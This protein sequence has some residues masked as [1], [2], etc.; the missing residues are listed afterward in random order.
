MDDELHQFFAFMS[1]REWI[2]LGVVLLGSLALWLAELFFWSRWLWLWVLRRWYR[3]AGPKPR[4]A[5]RWWFVHLLAVF[6]L[7]AFCYARFIEPNALVS[8]RLV[9]ETD[10]IPAG[11][12][13]RLVQV[14][15]LHSQ[16]SSAMRLV[17][18]A[19]E[20]AALRPDLVLLTG[21]YLCDYHIPSIEA[22]LG[23]AFR[24]P[25]VPAI[26]VPG[27]YGGFYPADPFLDQLGIE[28]LHTEWR[29]V[30]IRGVTFEILGLS[31]IRRLPVVPPPRHPERF[32]IVLEH[33]PA[34]LEPTAR[35]GWDLFLAGHTHAGQVRL[36]F[37]GAVV[38]LDPSGKEYEYGAYRL[39]RTIGYVN[40]GLGMECR[41][42][43]QVRFLAPPEVLLIELR[44][45]RK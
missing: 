25:N 7:A 27:N 41:G 44:G 1:L 23:F 33:F 15:D 34:L 42:W 8:R 38:T 26:A 12:T 2:A 13:L 11:M 14:S 45:T 5:W 16:A 19:E 24:L 36:P 28:V 40:A 20:I 22:L 29:E 21:D 4:I 39:G 18:A 30:T 32:G 6:Y 9:I 17:R 10:K 43:P 35:A 37:Y 31:P 3:A